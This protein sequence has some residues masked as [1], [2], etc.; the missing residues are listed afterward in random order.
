LGILLLRRNRLDEAVPELRRAA[1]LLPADAAS[2]YNLGRVLQKTG[3][4]Q[5]AAAELNK[6]HELNNKAQAAIQAKSLNRT[7]G[8]LLQENRFEEAATT[9][10]E[11]I[12][13]DPDSADVHYNHGLA[14]LGLSQLDQSIKE[15]QT[16]LALNTDQ[17]DAYYYLGRAWLAK[18]QPAEAAKN[19]AESL[20]RNPRDARAHNVR[21]VALAAMQQLSEAQKEFQFALDLDPQNSLFREN[22]GCLQRQFTGCEMKP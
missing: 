8:R 5:E 4:T 18:G 2:H 14:L 3:R 13:L 22:L 16:S 19:L 20:K 11:A 12:R 10:R 15:L 21:A 17:P 9:L 1:D 6:A 7:A